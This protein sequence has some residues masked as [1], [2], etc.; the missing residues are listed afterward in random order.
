MAVP[1]RRA[2]DWGTAM[3]GDIGWQELLIILIILALVFGASRVADLGGALGRG[4][5]EFRSEAS[6]TPDDPA[7]PEPD[8]TGDT[9]PRPVHR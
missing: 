9:G 3:I 8:A 4:I 5:R 1:L 6:A 7:A 2:H